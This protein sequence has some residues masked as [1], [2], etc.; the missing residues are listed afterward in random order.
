MD[1]SYL[2][3]VVGIIMV[4][5]FNFTNGFHDAADMIATAIAS[6]SMTPTIAIIIVTVFTF[7]GPFIGGLA[8]ANTIGEFV[9]VN[10]TNTAI[11]QNVVISAI[12]AAISYNLITWRLGL[13]S[14]S[15]NSLTSGLIGS[16]LFL[17]GEESIHWGIEALMHGK[18]VGFMK[19]ITGMLFSPLAG[20]IVGFLLIKLLLRV[21][22]RVT[23]KSKR[24]FIISQYFTV[25][26]LA[27]S[28]GTNDAQKGIG[29]AAMLLYASG[30][31]EQFTVPD[32]VIFLCAFAITFGTMFGGWSIIKTVGFGLYKIKLVHS[33]ADQIGSAAVILASSVIG[34][35]TSTTQV[36]TT[37][38]LGVGSGE[39][40]HHVRWGKAKS[41]AL[42]WLFNIPSS[43]LLGVIYSYLLSFIIH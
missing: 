33:L 39:H 25:S 20:F 2:I 7:A 17:L 22:R 19:V 11:A 14:S 34:A 37:T 27:F 9:E 8:V 12:M 32:W 38:L 23:I 26:W 16:G 10:P 5:I 13:P 18:I 31:Y 42:G 15:S 28:H 29:I 24:F 35:P 30:I 40:P 41:I 43:I 1:I 4:T 6:R 21:L 36:V 3:L